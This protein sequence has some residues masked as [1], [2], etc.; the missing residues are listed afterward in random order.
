M[1]IVRLPTPL[2]VWRDPQLE[3]RGSKFRTRQPSAFSLQTAWPFA[4]FSAMGAWI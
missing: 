4:L 1:S 2:S 3:I